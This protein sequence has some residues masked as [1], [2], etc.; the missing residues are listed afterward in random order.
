[1]RIYSCHRERAGREG[2]FQNAAK[3]E[4]DDCVT[5]GEMGVDGNQSFGGG[6]SSDIS[7]RWFL[8]ISSESSDFLVLSFS[9]GKRRQ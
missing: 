5:L 9:Q 3:R 2:E 1:M 7:F 4:N 6:M 8:C